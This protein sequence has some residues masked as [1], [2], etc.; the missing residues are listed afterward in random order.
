MSPTLID[1]FEICNR[2][3][4]YHNA[5]KVSY[6]FI[7]DGDTLYIYFE[8]SNGKV[9]WL[10]NFMFK[11]KPY[12]DMKMP[13]RV[14][15]GFLKCW[16]TIEDVI[17]HKI[18]ECDDTSNEKLWKKIIIVGYSHGG[19]LAVLCHECCWYHRPD[20]RDNIKTIAFEGP[21]VYGA[22]RVKKKLRERWKNFRL[23]R[24][25]TDIVTHLP[26]VIFGYTHVGSVIKINNK[27]K[28]HF[29]QNHT[30]EAVKESL[31]S[32]Q[33]NEDWETALFE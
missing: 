17:I 21:R 6:K 28:I 9:D 16:K 29:I 20:I 24:N 1:L 4:Y 15:K 22:F 14:H 26:P 12:K 32:Y 8:P 3:D 27:N 31:Q 18:N 19:A 10:H 30:S 13:Y 7:E 23:L 33:H 5:D 11:K 25:S 2:D